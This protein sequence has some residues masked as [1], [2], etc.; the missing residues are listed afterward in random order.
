METVIIT[1][2]NRT[3]M[4]NTLTFFET[5]DEFTSDIIALIYAGIDKE[6]LLQQPIPLETISL[7]QIKEHNVFSNTTALQTAHSIK[8]AI[9]NN[10]L[11]GE[12]SFIKT[13][14]YKFKDSN[15][16]LHTAKH[17]ILS[18][19]DI[20]EWFEQVQLDCPTL[21]SQNYK[22]QINSNIISDLKL[23][24]EKSDHFDQTDTTHPASDYKILESKIE[25]LT[26]E[27]KKLQMQVKNWRKAFEYESEG[28]NALYNLIE[29]NYFDSSGNQ[30]DI[31]ELPLKKELNSEWLTGRTLTE[32]DTIITSK[33]RRG[34]ANK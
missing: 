26:I 34:K 4:N 15:S 19:Y 2:W 13:L 28:L 8:N 17:S 5:S 7:E 25:M 18:R 29:N 32:A 10:I 9:E 23:S 16:L 30:L 24:L 1:Y 22:A 20:E 11:L 33:K 31:K 27:N 3:N 21:L 14:E 6:I 12:T